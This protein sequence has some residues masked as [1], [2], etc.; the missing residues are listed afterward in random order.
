MYTPS[1]IG[2]TAQDARPRVRG[3]GNVGPE[4][5][6]YTPTTPGYTDSVSTRY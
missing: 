1:L 5:P 6:V 3:V 4:R 2:C